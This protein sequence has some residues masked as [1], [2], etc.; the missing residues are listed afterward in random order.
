VDRARKLVRFFAFAALT[1]LAA[2][3]VIGLPPIAALTAQLPNSDGVVRLSGPPNRFVRGLRPG[4]FVYQTTIERDVSTI[5]LGTRTVSVTQTSYAGSPAWLLLESRSGDGIPAADSLLVDVLSLHPV[6]W[7]STLGRARIVA[8]FR[9]DS[10]FGALSAPATRRSI[11]AGLPAGTIVSG[12]ML[13]SELRLLPLQSAWE[14]STSTLVVTLGG[15]AV[16]P[17]RISVIGE[18]RVRVPAGQFDCWVVSVHAG[19]VAR[20]LYWV[21]KSDP[22][23][24]R[25][26]LDVPTMGGAQ[27]VSA[28]VQ[29]AR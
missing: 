17:T 27:L 5:V 2:L 26:S 19:D 7:S 23:V 20:G 11:V 16:L 10:A 8:E 22:I 21:T 3:A 25:S 24:V 1:T 29:I 9:A 15:N 4:E 28:L 14:D 18:D 6:H 13:E 12:P